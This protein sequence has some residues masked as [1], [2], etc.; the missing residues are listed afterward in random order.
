MKT[1][2]NCRVIRRGKW[3]GVGAPKT[4]LPDKCEGYCTHE[5]DEPYEQCKRCRYM[6]NWESEK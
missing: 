5:S 1:I 2:E 3:L 4:E 6:R